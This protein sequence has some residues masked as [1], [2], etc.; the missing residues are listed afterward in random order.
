METETSGDRVEQVGVL[1][2]DGDDLRHIELEEVDVV[3]GRVDMRVS[4][5]DED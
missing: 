4:D 1:D 3:E 5:N 2:R